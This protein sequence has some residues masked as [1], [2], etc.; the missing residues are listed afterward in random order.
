MTTTTLARTGP[1]CFYGSMSPPTDR[2]ARALAVLQEADRA[3]HGWTCDAST[4]C[5]RFGVTGR[6]PWVT[7]VEWELVVAELRR[8]GRRLPD[9]PEGDEGRCPFLDEAGRCRVYGARPL[10]CRTFFCE[11][12][13]G[14]AAFPRAALRALPRELEALTVKAPDQDTGARPLRSWL[15]AEGRPTRGRRRRG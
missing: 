2:T 12:G 9:I 6:E 11:R 5:C 13:H 14:P 15:A 3:L 10:G 1:L 4:E 8:T 7:Q